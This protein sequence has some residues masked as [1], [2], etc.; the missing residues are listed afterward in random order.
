[1]V[2]LAKAKSNFDAASALQ[3]IHLWTP[4]VHAMYYGVFLLIKYT[5]KEYEGLSYD[6]PET[7]KQSSHNT[8]FLELEKAFG[9]LSAQDRMLLRKS[10]TSLKR[11]REIADYSD[12]VIDQAYV[13]KSQSN[14]TYLID[15]ICNH[16]KFKL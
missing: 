4:V 2:I 7:I 14:V 11:D 16:F 5:L 6:L 1:M 13:S 15:T 10:Y 9:E 12:G 3:S 8:M